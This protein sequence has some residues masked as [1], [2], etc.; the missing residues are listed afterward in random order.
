MA[1]WASDDGCT[2]IIASTSSVI[3]ALRLGAGVNPRRGHA[4]R[5]DHS[6]LPATSASI[7]VT[8]LAEQM[9]SSRDQGA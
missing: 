9:L 5:T 8:P 3:G 2:T 1:G 6:Q 4:G 7:Y